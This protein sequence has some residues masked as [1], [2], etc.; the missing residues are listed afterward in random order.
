MVMALK[1][2]KGNLNLYEDAELRSIYDR[3]EFA[4]KPYINLGMLGIDRF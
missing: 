3:S 2:D 1:Q 4:S